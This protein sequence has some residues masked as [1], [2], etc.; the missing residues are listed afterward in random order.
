MTAFRVIWETVLFWGTSLRPELHK[1]SRPFPVLSCLDHRPQALGKGGLP[2]ASV[3][4][5][6]IGLALLSVA[7]VLVDTSGQ[8]WFPKK[9]RLCPLT[10]RPPG[11]LPLIGRDPHAAGDGWARASRAA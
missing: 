9:A 5:L 11:P 8:G 3:A 6:R 7:G 10:H 4:G 1:L 2:E